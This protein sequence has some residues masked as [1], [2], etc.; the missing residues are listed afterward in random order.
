MMYHT[1][2]FATNKFLT[3]LVGYGG[4]FESVGHS[5]CNASWSE[6]DYPTQRVHESVLS[7]VYV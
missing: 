2:S 6:C 3:Y 1:E 5:G 7:S 4:E